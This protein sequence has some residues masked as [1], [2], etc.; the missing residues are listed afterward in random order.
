MPP[1][2]IVSGTLGGFP[3]PPAMVRGEQSSPAPHAKLIPPRKWETV[4]GGM[5]GRNPRA[6]IGIG[7][8]VASVAAAAVI[9]IR[10]ARTP[11]PPPAVAAP[12]FPKP[13]E[14]HPVIPP[15]EEPVARPPQ[16]FCEARDIAMVAK[17]LRT[18]H[19]Q[20]LAV[21]KRADKKGAPALACH[22]SDDD[23]AL[24]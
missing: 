6:V 8:I 18:A 14:P 12:K 13:P 23:R 24:S 3:N 2:A 7:V 11:E 1:L 19:A 16:A 20:A 21:A 9:V 17:A 10:A 22:A 4:G 5:S 15:P